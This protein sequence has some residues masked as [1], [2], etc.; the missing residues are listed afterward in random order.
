MS[1]SSRIKPPKPVVTKVNGLTVIDGNVIPKRDASRIPKHHLTA[2]KALLRSRR[3]TAAEKL[4]IIYLTDML[5]D[6]ELCWPSLDTIS[7]ETGL[8]RSTVIRAVNS[9]VKSGAV[10]RVLGG[11]RG[12]STRYYLTQS[13]YPCQ[14]NPVVLC[15]RAC[16]LARC[17]WS[18]DSVS[19]KMT[20][21]E[22]VNSVNLTPFGQESNQDKQ[23]QSDTLY[24]VNSV[25]LTPFRLSFHHTRP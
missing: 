13:A 21:P 19:D 1:I 14:E 11:G 5:M 2:Y 20:V 12:R 23:C 6:N 4:I 9:F 16:E 15:D 3:F 10:I 22:D 24:P 17:P 25:N 7:E 8:P 18:D